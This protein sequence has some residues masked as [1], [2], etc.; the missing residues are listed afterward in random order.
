[1]P[2]TKQSAEVE[3]S[4][5]ADGAGATAAAPSGGAVDTS[6]KIVEAY[7]RDSSVRA[8]LQDGDIL[9]FRGE[10]LFSRVI[11]FGTN[12][13][14]SH[15]AMAFRRR[16][17]PSTPGGVGEERV[18]VVQA[19]GIGVHTLLLSEEIANYQGVCEVFRVTERFAP[20]FRR[21]VAVA[22][23]CRYVGRPYAFNHLWG[24]VVDSLTFGLYRRARSNARDRRAFFCSQLVARAYRRAG[25]DL[26]PRADAAT[27]P[28]D[29]IASH[30]VERVRVFARGE[31]VD[32]APAP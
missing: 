13:Q 28:G 20:K 21:D 22:E 16:D 1:M 24:F 25:V 15:A 23:A 12:S 29:I 6:P 4:A 7:T 8:A 3:V 14:Y 17:E 27:A 18:H 10:A 9:L 31:I 5:G 30:R 2:D 19:T 11:M 32:A 26:S